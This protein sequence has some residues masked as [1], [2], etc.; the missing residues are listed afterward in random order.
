ML[1]VGLENNKIELVENFPC[2]NKD[3][4]LVREQYWADKLG[5]LNSNQTKNLYT[6][7]EYYIRNKQ[8]FRERYLR[9]NSKTV[10]CECGAVLRV[11]GMPTHLKSKR[12]LI[13]LTKLKQRK[14]LPS[15]IMFFLVFFI[16]MLRSLT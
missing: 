16:V 15:I 12:H 11:L 7:H 9:I 3:D 4:A 2:K 14:H 8:E 6:P 1:N 10:K 5:T 13:N